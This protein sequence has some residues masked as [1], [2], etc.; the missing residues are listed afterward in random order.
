MTPPH[1]FTGLLRLVDERSAA[2]RAAMAS[3]PGF[4][5]PVPGCPGWNP[6]DLARHLGGGD[7]YWAAIVKAGPAAAPP[8]EAL[9][10]RAAL[11]AS[12]DSAVAPA[13]SG[14]NYRRASADAPTGSRC[15]TA[16]ASTPSARSSSTSPG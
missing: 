8:A 1:D 12:S 9:A 7:R 5:A 6:Y 10:A 2:F 16:P 13:S 14:T 11:V 15:S 3:A 4:D